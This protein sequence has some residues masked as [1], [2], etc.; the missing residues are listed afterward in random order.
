MDD[1]PDIVD[2]KTRIGD[3]EVDLMMGRHG[4][5]G[6]LTLVD[7]TTRFTRIETRTLQAG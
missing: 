4:G 7:R 6:L 5:G 2:E 3:G 1:R